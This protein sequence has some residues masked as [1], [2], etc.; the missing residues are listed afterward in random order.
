MNESLHPST[1]SEVLDRTAQLYRLRFLLFLVIA[2]LPMG[3]VL[4]LTCVFYLFLAWWTM[5]PAGAMSPAVARISAVVFFASLLF[6]ALPIFLAA[7][8]L[9]TAAMNHAAARVHM[10][11]TTT[12]RDTC[13]TI[14]RHGWRYI[15]LC[16][17]QI[18]FVWVIPIVAWIVLILLYAGMA[19]LERRAGMGQSS[20]VLFDAFAF[21]VLAALVGFSIW[22]LLRLSLAFPACVVEQVTAWTALKRSS[23]LC[24]GTR[25]RVFLLYLLGAALSCLLSFGV[26]LLLLILFFFLIPGIERPQHA[27]IAQVIW[28]FIFYGSCYAVQMLIRPVFGIALTLFYYDQRIRLEGYDIERMMDVAGLNVPVTPASGDGSASLVEA[29]EEQV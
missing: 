14:W 20:A 4:V 1:L 24:K 6:V 13:K 9:A 28:L 2:I 11:E 21:L 25:G 26:M 7:K 16:F 5:A 23:V 10:G 3:V 8:A 29:T 12:I 19:A 27:H 22:I 15:W 17:L 18:L